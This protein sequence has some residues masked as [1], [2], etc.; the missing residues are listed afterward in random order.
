MSDTYYLSMILTTSFKAKNNEEEI[1][2]VRV[3]VVDY[4]DVA[5]LVKVF[6]ENNIDTVIST[7]GINMDAVPELNLIQASERAKTMRRYIPSIWSGFAYT[8]E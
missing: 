1:A 4:S 7:I 2:G 5:A 8:P 3:V 6:E